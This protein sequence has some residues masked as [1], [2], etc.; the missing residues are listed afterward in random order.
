MGPQREMEAGEEST[1]PTH[2]LW[3]CQ[4]ALATQETPVQEKIPNA[5][6]AL[7]PR[8]ASGKQEG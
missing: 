3:R 8:I 7:P 1:G 6:S 2:R 5:G 4:S